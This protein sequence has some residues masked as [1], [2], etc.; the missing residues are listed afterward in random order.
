MKLKTIRI[1]PQKL[2]IWKDIK[3]YEGLYRISNLG[4]VKSLSRITPGAISRYLPTK[5]LKTRIG[6]RGYVEIQLSLNGVRTHYSIHQLVARAFIP[7]PE[8]KPYIDHINGDRTD[9]R[10]NNLRWVTHKENM[11]N[12]ITRA[13]ITERQLGE[14]SHWWNVYGEKHPKSKKV[15][16]INTS[17][18]YESITEAG[19]KTGV[20]RSGINMVCRGERKYAGKDEEGKPLFWCYVDNKENTEITGLED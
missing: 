19:R 5:I 2:E 16:C 10:Y 11:N 14:K 3:G 13:R 6:N 4:K 12:P 20:N 18:I 9:N 1:K 17:V 7:N 15:M 8:N